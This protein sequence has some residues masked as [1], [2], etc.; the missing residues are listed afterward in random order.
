M[1]RFQLRPGGGQRIEPQARFRDAGAVTPHAFRGEDRLDVAGEL[2]RGL[3]RG[4]IR[5]GAANGRGKAN[6]R[7]YSAEP[8]HEP[9]SSSTS[10]RVGQA[11][12][13]ER[14]PTLVDPAVIDGRPAIASRACPTLQAT[15]TPSPSLCVVAAGPHKGAPHASLAQL[16][17]Q[18][19]VPVVD[20]ENQQPQRGRVQAAGA[21]L[22]GVARVPGAGVRPAVAW[23]FTTRSRIGAFQAFQ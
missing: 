10:R 9:C 11:R 15:K 6:Q 18:R 4:F 23:V 22:V 14:R 17:V 2:D 3:R 7:R 12:L 19:Q 5:P 1:T 13:C 21:L 20:L 16:V 8:P